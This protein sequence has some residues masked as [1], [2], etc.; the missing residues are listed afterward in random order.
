MIAM[1]DLFTVK[2]NIAHRLIERFYKEK[3]GIENF[4]PWFAANFQAL[5][6]IEGSIL[7]TYG[8]EPE[9]RSFE[10]SLRG[11]IPVLVNGLKNNGWEVLESEMTIN[12]N[13]NGIAMQGIMD[14]VAK[15]G[16]ERLVVDIKYSGLG[17]RSNLLKNNEDL[18][19]FF[20]QQMLQQS[21]MKA[22]KTAYFIVDQAKFITKFPG[23]LKEAIEIGYKKTLEEVLDLQN[24][25]IVQTLEWRK[26]QLRENLLELRHEGAVKHLETVYES[27]PILDYLEMKSSSDPHDK[28]L[29]LLSNNFEK[30]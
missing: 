19:L 8:Y 15:R 7:L 1:N 24:K 20:Y 27:E 9:R 16:E 5:L 4:D 28:Y 17:K 21:E 10:N 23:V 22:V 3:V 18:Q 12:G 11:A 2:G 6:E 14:L 26:R 25:Q 29:T 13:F 30:L